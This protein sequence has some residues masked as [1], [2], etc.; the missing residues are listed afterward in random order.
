[1]WS[2][3]SRPPRL[4][5]WATQPRL[6]PWVAQLVGMVLV[7]GLVGWRNHHVGGE[8]SLT[9]F[10]AG[11]NFYIG[12]H[13]GATGRYAPL[14]RGH[15]SP[16]FERKDATEL[17]QAEL[18][19]P[20]TPREVSNFWLAKARAYIKAH[21]MRW[22]G[23]LLYKWML[24]WNAYEIP[25]TESYTLYARFSWL[26]GMLSGL[27]HFGVLCPLAGVGLAATARRWR[28]LWVLYAMILTVAAGVAVFYVLG[29]YRYPLVPLL[30]IFAG[31]GLCELWRVIRG[32]VLR[33]AYSDGWVAHGF[34]RGGR[35][36]AHH[37]RPPP[38]KRWSTHAAQQA[39]NS[40][41]RPWTAAA[42]VVSI[43]LVTNLRINPEHEL[44]GMAYANLGVVLGQQGNY[45]AAALFLETALAEVPDSVE[46]HY[47]LGMAYRFKGDYRRALEHF[48]RA[49][50][51]DPQLMEV[52][53]Q[54]GVIYETL[55]QPAEAIRHYERALLIDPADDQARRRLETLI[56]TATVRERPY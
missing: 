35:E 7:L 18:G 4:K 30:A 13:E 48:C 3:D 2:A 22:F 37:S 17:A 12:N 54:M 14:K 26:L 41:L 46:T 49:R 24:V 40:P 44:D 16:P 39:E 11:P 19:Q 6:K 51:L 29:R 45:D 27:N 32:L 36:S 52:D 53:F 10:Q 1:E 21:P 50:E 55:G 43:A 25:D 34:S 56:S 38:L 8:V 33:S 9:T 42:L 23:L 28:G 31:A 15:E 47:N 5:P 20:L